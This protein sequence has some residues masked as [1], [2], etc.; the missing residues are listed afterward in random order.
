MVKVGVHVSIA[1]SLDQAVDRAAGLGCD[2]FQMFSRNPRGWEY[3]PLTG[4]DCTTF[5]EKI[6]L[7]RLIPVDHMPYLP[8]LASPKEDV[9]EKSVSTLTAELARCDCLGIPYLVTHLGHHLGD[10]IAGGRKR[11]IAAINKALGFSDTHAMLLLENTAGEKNS[12][13]SSF[14]HIRSIMD[15]IE[16]KN[17]IGICF[18]TCH[19][20]AAGY[21]L[22][23]SDG[24]TSTLEQF[25]DVIGFGNLKAVHL[26]DCK[27]ERGS[28]LDRHEHI[29]MGSI[30]E[31][32]FRRILCHTAFR[33]LPFICET[34]VDERRGDEGNIRKVRELSQ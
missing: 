22:R 21:E 11:V 20:F 14:E 8:N 33:D 27:G 30:G 19:A 7:S 23:T 34:P 28:G 17:R 26:N 15:G 3:K 5:A 18:D 12:V 16:Q 29:G 31:E 4:I 32:G 6:R 10:G 13:G 24:L 1:G 2:T 25:D 9:Y